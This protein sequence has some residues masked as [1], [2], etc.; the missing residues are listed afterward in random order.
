MQGLEGRQAVSVSA[1]EYDQIRSMYGGFGLPEDMGQVNVIEV[2]ADQLSVRAIKNAIAAAAN[3]T[4]SRF[5]SAA[6]D[7]YAR[8]GLAK[9][10][11]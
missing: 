3:T 11:E 2:M 10:C 4:A 8:T 1:G 6:D 9:R 7:R 5:A